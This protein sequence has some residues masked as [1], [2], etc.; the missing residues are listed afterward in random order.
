MLIFSI[1]S[2]P[3][4]ECF[5][6][7]VIGCIHAWFWSA[8][9]NINDKDIKC[10]HIEPNTY[11]TIQLLW[12]STNKIGCAIGEQAHGDVRV[13][14]YFSPGAPFFLETKF[15]CGILAHKDITES[16]QENFTDITGNTFLSKL[17]INLATDIN[18]GILKKDENLRHHLTPE[19][20]QSRSRRWGVVSLHHIYKTGWAR[21]KI[22]DKSNGSIGFIA[23]LVTRYK[24]SEEGNAR[25]DVDEAV[26]EIGEPG[27]MCVETGRKFFALCYEFRDPTPGYRLVAVLAPVAL[28]TLI[29]YDL[30]SGVM[31]QANY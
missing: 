4:G 15:Y 10:G 19:A 17:G 25:C 3:L 12:A 16:M 20:N 28:F 24:F 6:D 21:S 26:Y 18:A 14:C 27:S 5:V 22:G 29:L 2:K 30:F 7:P 1:R 9:K 11:N 23:K 13:I 8:G 31:R